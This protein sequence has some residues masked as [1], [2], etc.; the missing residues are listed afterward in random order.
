L[1]VS[2]ALNLHVPD[3]PTVRA[4]EWLTAVNEGGDLAQVLQADDGLIAWLWARWSTL[5]SQGLSRDAFTDV[6]LGYRREV[7]IWLAGERTWVHACSGLIGR[8][9]RRMAQVDTSVE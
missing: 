8:I 7:W 2:A 5:S 3:E 6:V 1:S 4:L 9:N